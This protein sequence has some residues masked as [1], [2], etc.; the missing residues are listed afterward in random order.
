MPQHSP[1]PVPRPGFRRF[2]SVRL[3]GVTVLVGV[4]LL[5]GCGGNSERPLPD[6]RPP[7]VDTLTAPQIVTEA[8]RALAQ[9]KS[10]H[11]TGQYRQGDKPVKLDMRIAAGNTAVGTVTSNGS[12]VELRRLGDKLYVKGDDT[13]L[14]ALGEK[15][16]ATK[17]KWLVGP[18][19]QADRSL[20]DLTDLQR[21]AATLS[22]GKGKLVK[23]PVRDL[24][25]QQAVSVLNPTGV[26]L[27][28]AATGAPYPLRLE[29]LGAAVG[30]IDYGDYNQPVDVKAPS[31]TV[32]LAS[33]TS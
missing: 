32:D 21:F 6:A 23:E 29:R 1:Q 14:A 24:H 30:S 19:A 20:A 11:I 8:E 15:A 17:G 4:A 5:A 26:R 7:A 18:V 13:F 27:W 31:P 2:A 22:P 12:T 9:A 10:V 25:G 3:L 28:V 33:V 16:K